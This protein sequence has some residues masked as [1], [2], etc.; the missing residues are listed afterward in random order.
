[1]NDLKEQRCSACH[2]GAPQVTAEEI[3]LLNSQIPD[4]KIVTEDNI[5]K[6]RREYRFN[7]FLDALNF[8]NRV[9]LQAEREDHHPSITTE[10]G[11]VTVTWWTHKIKGLH[12]NDFIMAAKT[13]ALF[14]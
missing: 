7:N 9:A 11:K 2:A 13:D 5:R 3:Q 6:L 12:R 1:M 14:H 8:T 4:W 10:W